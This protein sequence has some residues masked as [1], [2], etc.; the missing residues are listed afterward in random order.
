MFI[1]NQPSTEYQVKCAYFL[2]LS[3]LKFASVVKEF[4][5]GSLKVMVGLCVATQKEDITIPRP[6]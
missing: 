4:P 2:L 6:Y 5:S 3:L 1:S